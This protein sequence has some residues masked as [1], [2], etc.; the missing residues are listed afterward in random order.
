MK[1]VKILLTL[2]SIYVI[3]QIV[4]GT[5]SITSMPTMNHGMQ[6]F[7]W[8]MVASFIGIMCMSIYEMFQQDSGQN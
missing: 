4:V 3:V 8:T 7:I 1:P 5:A 6:G 2:I